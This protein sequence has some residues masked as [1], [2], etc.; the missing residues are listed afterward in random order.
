LYTFT[1]LLCP[2]LVLVGREASFVLALLLKT[3][4]LFLVKLKVKVKQDLSTS[5]YSYYYLQRVCE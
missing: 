2:V 1:S 3:P 5:T 4:L